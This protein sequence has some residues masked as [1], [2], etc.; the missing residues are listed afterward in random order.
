MATQERQRPSS[1]FV[2]GFSAAVLAVAIWTAA[3]LATNLLGVPTGYG[4]GIDSKLGAQVVRDFLADQDAEAA[5]LSSADPGPLGG[6]LTDSALVDVSQEIT[7]EGPAGPPPQVTFQPS[8]LTVLRA[9]DPT[10]ASLTI[11]V[12]E[13]GTKTAVSSGGQS[14]APTERTFSF[15]ADFW[16]RADSRGHYTI[17]DQ[18]FQIQPSSPL[19]T[20]ALI[21]TALIAVVL[22]GTL[23]WRQRGSRLPLAPA[24]G[25]QPVTT[26]VLPAT[27]APVESAEH[28]AEVV[29]RTFGGL[30]IQHAG[31]NWAQSVLSRP[32]TGFVWLRLLV[33]AI[34]DPSAPPAR[35]E[36]AR[37]VT[38]GLSRE[39]QLKRLRNTIAK[40]LPELPPALKDRIVV[41]PD[42]M[43]FR[44]DGCEVDAVELLRI[45]AEAGSRDSLPAALLSRAQGAFDASSGVFLPEFEKVEDLATDRRPTCTELIA[46][47]REHLSAKRLQ[48][49]LLLADTYLA[50]QRPLQAIAVLE[51]AHRERDDRQDL[52]K[53]LVSAYRQVGREAEAKLLDQRYA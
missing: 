36:L 44:L 21:A 43:A 48:L 17:A 23:A 4:N 14:A 8:R 27:T 53:R 37:Q 3:A 22:A 41:E 9:A 24:P 16:L 2:V 33:A 5:A 30:Q 6:H 39:V 29:I 34:R 10:D 38:P 50:E 32:V 1:A 15:Q 40:G 49:A 35:D 42:A 13:E 47:V 52:A 7:A 45:S 11:K 51:P 28:A 19:S 26:H 20:I 46:Q 25:R 12:E 31:K 18:N